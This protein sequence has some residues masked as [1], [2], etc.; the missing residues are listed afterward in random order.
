MRRL[1][2]AAAVCAALLLPAAAAAAAPPAHVGDGHHTAG[3]PG[4]AAAVSNDDLA[5]ARARF[6]P[7]AARLNP[8]SSTVNGTV[9]DYYGGLVSGAEVEWWGQASSGDWYSGD[10]QTDGAGNYSMTAMP[11]TNGDVYAGYDN[12]ATTLAYQAQTWSDGGTKTLHF[13]PGRVYAEAS[14]GGPWAEGFEYLGV[15][16]WGTDR[17]SYGRV[18]ANGTSTPNGLFDVQQGTYYWGSAK[19]F[20]D[21]GVEF[22]GTINVS[23]G[24]QAG[25]GIS[26]GEA[27]A[28]RL[29]STSPY[30]GS[31]KPG[32]TFKIR[33]DNFPAGWVNNVTGYTDDPDGTAYKNFGDKTSSGAAQQSL[34]VKIPAGAKPG[35]SYWVGFQHTNDA[36]TLY[37]ETP[38]QVA[39]MKATK[40]SIRRGTRIRL[41]GVVPTEGHWGDQ[42]GIKKLLT[43]YAHK[44]TAKV[45]TKWTPASQGWFKLG[46]MRTNGKGAYTTPYFKP[47]STHTLVVRYP[48]DD[49]YW[50]AYTSAQKITVR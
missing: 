37:L 46:T 11:T 14:L 44:G 42:T 26:V 45:P 23:S 6:T 33:R 19:F 24:S 9:R 32:S 43:V 13:Y 28:Q 41:S 40:T 18:P 12:G 5:G 15:R 2:L 4:A 10:G 35:Y 38:F 36:A 27:N 1:F 17:Y 20:Y 30:W 39:T 29:V 16:V 8:G 49:W 31:G 22:S 25:A 7:L 50:G 47:P 48:G 21:E 3:V 34:S